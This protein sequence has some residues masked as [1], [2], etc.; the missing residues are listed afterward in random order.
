MDDFFTI[1][2][3]ANQFPIFRAI[4]ASKCKQPIIALYFESETV[5]KFYNL[6]VRCGECTCSDRM[7]NIAD[8]DQ[9]DFLA[10]CKY[11]LHKTVKTQNVTF[12]HGLHCFLRQKHYPGTEVH[13]IGKFYL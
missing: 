11:V 1:F 3:I 10:L 6:E 8:H 4:M 13:H 12:H 9:T 7:V 2:I 5:L